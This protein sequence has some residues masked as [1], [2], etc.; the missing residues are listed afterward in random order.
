MP[1]EEVGKS[2]IRI[3]MVGCINPP[4]LQALIFG[5]ISCG[6]LFGWFSKPSFKR[7]GSVQVS[8]GGSSQRLLQRIKLMATRFFVIDGCSPAHCGDFGLLSDFA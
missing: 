7:I 1:Q 3:T 2:Q 6:G 5:R 8:V 4:H